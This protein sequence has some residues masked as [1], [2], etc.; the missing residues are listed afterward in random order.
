[1]MRAMAASGY[2]LREKSAWVRDAVDEF[3]A[4]ATWQS[5]QLSSDAWKRLVVDTEC[6]RVSNHVVEQ[7]QIP[8]DLHIRLW[9]A[10]IDAA[11]WGSEQEDPV[12]LEISIASVL[13]A[14][15]VWKLGLMDPK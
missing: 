5:R 15:I 9:R 2:G 14:A 10:S 11:I 6:V 8:S 13:R 3:L 1:M 4:D 12:Y 7:V